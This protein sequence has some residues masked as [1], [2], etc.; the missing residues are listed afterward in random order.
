MYGNILDLNRE[1]DWVRGWDIRLSPRFIYYTPY[2][3]FEIE[4]GNYILK[5]AKTID[6]LL[7]VFELR[8]ENFLS[9]TKSEH[10][11][12]FDVDEYDHICDH[13][14]IIDKNSEKIIGTYRVI[15]S[16]ISSNFYSQSEFNLDEF[17]DL[18]GSK[19]ELGRACID[20][21]HR[22]GRVIDLLWKGIGRYCTIT[23]TK[24][25]FGC[26]SVKN[27]DDGVAWQ[28]SEYFI[29]NN[30]SLKDINIS[31]LEKFKTPNFPVI[32]NSFNNR[33]IPS[34]LRSYMMAGAKV[35]LEPAKDKDFECYDFLTVLNLSLIHI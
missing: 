21:H 30:D 27:I 18:K 6:E 7:D 11:D 17:L 29:E 24:Y 4:T 33:L 10:P 26:S 5:V 13:I 34:L 20:V 23:K 16:H 22:N 3:D 15:S 12:S 31:V 25:L 28:M 2:L 32:E 19:L 9:G 35:C 14:I 1:I 8:H